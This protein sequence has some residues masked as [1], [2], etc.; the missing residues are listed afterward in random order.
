MKASW[1]SI[2]TAALCSLGAALLAYSIAIEPNWVEVSVHQVST[3][4]Q[5]LRVALLS[6]LHLQGMGRREASIAEHLEKIEPDLI[7]LSGDVIDKSDAI[8]VLDRF[9]KTLGPAH[10]MAFLGNWEYWA[11]VDLA[12]LRRLYE[13]QHGV[14]LLINDAVTYQVRERTV[15]VVG[16]DD[17]TAGQP[18]LTN[19]T[20]NLG[21]GTTLLV[22]HSPGWFT[23]PQ[24]ENDKARFDL[25]F[26]GHTHGGQITFFGWPIWTPRGSGE[27]ESGFYE[28]ANCRL[29]V[30]RGLGTSVMPARFG[31]R[32]EIA[33]FDL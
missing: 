29:Y 30:S 31:S 23:R 5:K 14:R 2:G 1:V 25:C 21:P 15:H 11:D 13:M 12:A 26:A 27:F 4:R 10:K 19:R 32:P 28:T 18:K 8:P 22:Q 16:L 7:V 20:S 3:D 24:A 33:V 6:D 17:Y 9:L